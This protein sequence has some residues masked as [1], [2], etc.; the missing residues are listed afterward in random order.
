MGRN[1][2]CDV[3]RAAARAESRPGAAALTHSCRTS[4]DASVIEGGGF[5]AAFGSGE[6]LPLRTLGGCSAFRVEGPARTLEPATEIRPAVRQALLEVTETGLADPSRRC[7]PP[8][9]AS[10]C[11]ARRPALGGRTPR[12]GVTAGRVLAC[13]GSGRA[14]WRGELPP[15]KDPVELARILTAFVQGLRVLGRARVGRSLLEDALAVAMRALN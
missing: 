15:G 5:P 2:E 13:G 10:W 6:R 11:D 14:R 9:S 1:G 3:G 8:A 7:L 4:L 12:R